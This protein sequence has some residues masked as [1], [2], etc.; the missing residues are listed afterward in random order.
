MKDDL[1]KKALDY[2]RFPQ[3][4]KISV[5]PTKPAFTQEDL[6]LCYTPGVAEPVKEIVQDPF[7]LIIIRAKAI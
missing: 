2:H 4:G 6:S 1:T 3:P 5:T 7:P